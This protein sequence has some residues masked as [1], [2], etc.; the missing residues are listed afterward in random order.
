MGVRNR[1]SYPAYRSVRSSR[2]GW[3]RG[4]VLM[5]GLIALSFALGF[6]VLARLLPFNQHLEE[7]N[8]SSVVPTT[9]GSSSA[10]NAASASPA[11]TSSGTATPGATSSTGNSPKSATA[12]PT[13]STHANTPGPS[14][15]P[16]D[17]NKPLVQQ[18]DSL[19]SGPSQTDAS[20]NSEETTRSPFAN[21]TPSASD[22]GENA[23]HSRQRRRAQTSELNVSQTPS[24]L[25]KETGTTAGAADTPAGSV[26]GDV[27]SSPNRDST[28]D[29]AAASSGPYRVQLG[30]FATREKAEQV[31]Q[32]ARDKGFSIHIRAYRTADGQR[33]YRVQNGV[34]RHRRSAESALQRL[35]DA[36]FEAIIS[37]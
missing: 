20:Q 35:K 9:S 26:S 24:S 33:L 14:I 22:H 1:E 27:S 10:S 36:G 8:N 3:L 32:P 23:P 29:H 28:G 19:D 7:T 18:P 37:Q 31:A 15:D 21:L 4:F 25:D 11:V 30:V 2:T 5:F 34:F 12:A 16:V 6:F 17:E 13:T